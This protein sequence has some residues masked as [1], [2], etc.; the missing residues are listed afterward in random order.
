VPVIH[1]IRGYKGS[2]YSS[3]IT[4]CRIQEGVISEYVFGDGDY[5]AVYSNQASVGRSRERLNR[6]NARFDEL[7]A[8][9]TDFLIDVEIGTESSE[10]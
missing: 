8:E 3:Y 10:S 2:E 9:T 1:G 7:W 4:E 6:L 5:C